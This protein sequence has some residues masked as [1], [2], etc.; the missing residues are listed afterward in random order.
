MTA[1]PALDIE[2]ILDEA[3]LA[4]TRIRPYVRET[5]LEYSPYLSR[6]SQS[7]VYLKL[8]NQQMTGSFKLRGAA[9]K[10]LS[11]TAHERKAGAVTASTGNHGHAVAYLTD[12]LGIPGTIYLPKT[13]IAEKIDTLKMYQPEIRFHGTDCLEAETAARQAAAGSGQAFIS[14]YND[15]QVIAGQAT[16]AIEMLRQADRIDTVLAPVGGG[17][18]I[19]GIA[20]WL[21]HTEQ[22]IDVFGCQPEQSRVMYES[23]KAGQ[24]VDMESLPT[25]SD[26]TAGGIEEGAL[27]FDICRRHVDDIFLL[28]EAEIRDALKLILVKHHV[29]IEGAAALPVAALLQNARRWHGKKVVLVLSGSKISLDTLRTIVHQE[30]YDA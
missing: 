22:E 26:G 13:T 19:S 6:L 24:I 5:P 16:V 1:H 3:R 17:G 12:L 28:A 11:L 2:D 20:A 15:P 8:E 10:L 18:L 4:E 7:D 14:P 27:T 29:L 25:L 30:P 9:N 23:L 21:K